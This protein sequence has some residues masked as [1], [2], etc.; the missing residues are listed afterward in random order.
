MTPPFGVGLS[1]GAS[2]SDILVAFR[3]TLRK[4]LR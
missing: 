1:L 3:E 2:N 4:K